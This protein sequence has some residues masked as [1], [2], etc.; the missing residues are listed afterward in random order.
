[1]E[2][3]IQ[4]E[5]KYQIKQDKIY[6]YSSLY[7]AEII[8]ATSTLRFSNPKDFNDPF[9]CDEN[10]LDFNI[11]E[12]GN[13]VEEE[14]TKIA[15]ALYE[16]NQPKFTEKGITL[17]L[18]KK[19]IENDPITVGGYKERLNDVAIR[20]SNVCCFSK[21]FKSPLMWSH[22]SDKHRG[23]CFEFN[24]NVGLDNIFPNKTIDIIGQVDYDKTNKINYLKD[25]VQ[26][27]AKLFLSKCKDWS[28]EEE[29]RMI[30]R[31]EKGLVKFNKDFLSGVS[32]GCRVND[33]DVDE[34]KALC[35]KH[36]YNSLN[37]MRAKKGDFDLTFE[38]L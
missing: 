9:D 30:V 6:K 18:L 3:L 20:K 8:I 29:V 33:S 17:D 35:S 38:I 21:T 13:D 22:Y 5:E 28:Y 12:K 11:A 26:A 1:M 19:V 36:D 24:L 7:T 32:F 34:I 4:I 14:I 2:E 16:L 37:F 31:N 10:V 25:K 27:I 23:I 15:K